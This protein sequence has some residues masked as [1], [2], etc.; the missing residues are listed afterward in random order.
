MRLLSFVQQILWCILGPIWLLE[1]TSKWNFFP[2]ASTV[3][4]WDASTFPNE[5]SR[6]YFNQDPCIWIHLWQWP[7][8]SR[9]W[10]MSLGWLWTSRVEIVGAPPSLHPWAPH[11]LAACISAP[12]S[13]PFPLSATAGFHIS[14]P[15]WHLHMVLISAM[16]QSCR[17]CR[18]CCHGHSLNVLYPSSSCPSTL[19]PPLPPIPTLLWHPAANKSNTKHCKIHDLMNDPDV[20]QALGSLA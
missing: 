18:V 9:A 13:L 15:T 11:K 17:W 5:T 14:Y 3:N 20:L 16:C 4:L 6:T 19:P 12:A 8:K 1:R 7:V 10:C 2:Q